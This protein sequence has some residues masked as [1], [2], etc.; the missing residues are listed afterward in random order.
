MHVVRSTYREVQESITGNHPRIYRQVSAGAEI[1][2][3]ALP[4]DINYPDEIYRR[5]NTIPIIRQVLIY[6]PLI[7]NPPMNKRSG[8]FEPRPPEPPG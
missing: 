2:A 8:V 3:I 5:L 7:F 6:P 4:R 1:A